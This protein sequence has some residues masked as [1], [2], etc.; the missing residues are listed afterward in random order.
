MLL[1]DSQNNSLF[2]AE[3]SNRET[4]DVELLKRIHT[5]DEIAFEHL[6]DKYASIIY[7]LLM[8]VLK[9]VT[10]ADDIMHDIFLNIWNKPSDFEKASQSIFSQ[11]IGIARARALRRKKDKESYKHFHR[12]DI[13]N[14][15]LYAEPVKP[16]SNA[17]Y[18][19]PHDTL[20]I[21]DTIKKMDSKQQQIFALAFYEGC[22]SNQ[23]F[24]VMG[25]SVDRIKILL[26]TSLI[27][28]KSSL[29][30]EKQSTDSINDKYFELCAL[31]CIDFLQ[32]SELLELEGHLASRCTV[33]NREI[34][35]F[36]EIIALL[37][38]A[39][40][41]ISPPGELKERILFSS[42]L[43]SVVKSNSVVSENESVQQTMKHEE[44]EILKVEKHSRMITWLVI[45][46]ILMILGF[47]YYIYSLLK[48]MNEQRIF[49][50]RQQ[51][52]ISDLIDGLEGK[53]AIIGI[54]GA[55]RV[56][57][58]SLNSTDSSMAAYGKVF[59]DPDSGEA[60]VQVSGLPVISPKQNYN[61]WIEL[62]NETI[63][64][65]CFSITH[66]N[67]DEKLLKIELK[68][69]K[70]SEIGEFFITIESKDARSVPTGTKVLTGFKQ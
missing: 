21:V 27:S 34:V 10:D 57:I 41:P 12:G 13:R 29:M 66:P 5:R 33:C 11:I 40:Q 68:N 52:L 59:W 55:P 16:S 60:I 38:L 43:A 14:F 51:S 58:I 70:K 8:R 62:H 3:E 39:L 20:S 17:G 2:F 42:R 6:Y 56:E 53:N 18:N 47:G 23:I 32:G 35:I 15:A 64:V 1:M 44:P 31:Y 36:K 25:I 46:M 69:I 4:E 45:G 65:G 37:T 22:T 26:Q 50:N 7:S 54:L 24:E 9:S 30:I 48:T 61:I 67:D 19:L 49:E 28:F 63:N